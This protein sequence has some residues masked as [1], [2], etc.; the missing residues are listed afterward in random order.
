MEE[1]GIG[2]PSTYASIVSTIQEREYVRKEQNRLHPRGQGPAGHRLPRQ[3]LRPLRRLR[4]HRRPRGGPRPRHH[5]RRG[6][7]GAARPVLEGLLRRARRD[8][9][10]S[11]HRGA[12]TRSTRC[13]S[14]TSSRRPRRISSRAAAR[15]AAAGSSASRPR[16]TVRPS[17]AARTIPSAAT[18]APSPAATKATRAST[19]RSSAPAPSDGALLE[20]RRRRTQPVTLHKGPYGYYVQLGEA[21]D[22][23]KPPR[24]S[25]PKGMDPATL[26][27]ER[28]LELL[29]LPRLIGPHPEDGVPIEAGIGRFGPF[30]KHGKTY[31]NLSRPRGGLHHRHEPRGGADR[32]E[33]AARRPGRG[34]QAAPRARRRIPRAARSRSTRAA[35]GPT[36]SG[37]RSTRRCRRNSRRRRSASRRPWR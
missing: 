31:A 37:R 9:G 28:A 6:L 17:S 7:E 26:A 34:G 35:T 33:G 4:L 3:L 24:A 21:V 11:D 36:S 30:V 5:R 15:S 25:I 8:R 16:A 19:A 29:S 2:R 12:S 27:L 13:W 18:P 32:A 23:E 22:G 14:R 10:P 1:L 20:E